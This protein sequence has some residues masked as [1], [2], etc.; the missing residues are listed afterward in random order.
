MIIL[1]YFSSVLKNLSCW[2]TQE[3]LGEMLL[4]GIPNV[5]F[6]GEIRKFIPELSPNTPPY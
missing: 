4:N 6:H 2:G 1:G 5:Y 3:C